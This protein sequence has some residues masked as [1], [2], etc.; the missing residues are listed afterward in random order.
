MTVKST[1]LAVDDAPVN[2]TVIAG[3]LKDEYEVKLATSG[4]KA[5]DIAFT[6]PPD[7]ILLDIMMPE[8]DGYGVCRRLK[9][10]TATS[11]IPVIFLTAKVEIADEELGFEVG[12]VDFIHKPIS[13][14]I[15]KARVKAQLRLRE[16]E[17]SLL[18]HNAWL[19]SEVERRMGELRRLQSASVA[20]MVSLA[21]FRD[22][23]TGRHI[24]RTQKYVE[25]LASEL[26][27][28][29]LYTPPL[30]PALIEQMAEMAPLHD[31]G[32]IAIPDSILLK[33]GKLDDAE[34]SVMKTHA[35]RGGVM[36]S[37]C[38]ETMGE[39]GRYLQVAM[40]IARHHHERWDGSGYPDQ[41]AGQSI[42][43]EARIMAVADVYDALRSA[44]PYKA[45]F[46]H[47]EANALMARG[48][49][50]QFDPVMLDVWA[51][52]VPA[53]QAIASQWADLPH[54]AGRP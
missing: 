47:D 48:R 30:N 10:A 23:E 16:Y 9:S 31:I 29:G 54:A 17:A 8:M 6:Q 28:L 32:K 20:T 46:S 41:L 5:L 42:P 51:G 18:D 11:R 53:I 50:T 33:P 2:L 27:R 14:A 24:I 49:G 35:E 37:Q 19:Q 21:E 7:L 25:L 15:L 26:Y 39:T 52:L 40:R 34:W 13:P 36:L 3:T 4:R 38:A 12:A 1:I 22:N 44:R 43:I 45:P